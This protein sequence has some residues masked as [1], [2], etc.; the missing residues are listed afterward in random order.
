MPQV[1]QNLLPDACTAPH[2]AQTR[3]VG[4]TLRDSRDH[5][6]RTNTAPRRLS[7]TSAASGTAQAGN[8]PRSVP[9]SATGDAAGFDGAA[10]DALVAGFRI[11]VVGRASVFV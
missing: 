1:P 7:T 3:C 6:H 4:G 10:A 2:L 9:F 8:P 11:S 5:R